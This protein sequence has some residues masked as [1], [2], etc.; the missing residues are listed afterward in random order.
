MVDPVPEEMKCGRAETMDELRRDFRLI[1]GYP[2]Q[3]LQPVWWNWTEFDEVANGHYYY[4]ED[5]L[6]DGRWSGF[7][8][9]VCIV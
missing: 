1:Q 6:E 9:Q 4:E 3:T 2:D 7:F 5:N 8:M